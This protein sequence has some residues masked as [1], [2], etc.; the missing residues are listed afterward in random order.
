MPF[1]AG[2]A[3]GLLLATLIWLG[4]WLPDPAPP[5]STASPGETVPPP[6]IRFEFPDMLRDAEVLVPY[7]EEYLQPDAP[8][9]ADTDYMLQAGAFRN[10]DDADRRRAAILLLDLEARTLRVSR[11]GETWHR[12]LVGPFPGRNRV[13]D[14]QLQLLEE[15][16]DSIVLRTRG[17][18]A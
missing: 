5:P 7:V 15:D 3:S 10:A 14:A 13:R 6:G 4:G 12:V 16:I 1:L 9:E 17:D 11:Q 2:L 8:V 18:D